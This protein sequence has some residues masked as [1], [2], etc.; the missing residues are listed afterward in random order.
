MR[1]AGLRRHR[2]KAVSRVAILTHT[3]FDRDAI[4]RDVRGMTAW[5]ESCGHFVEIF[6][7][8]WEEP[9]VEPRPIEAID[10]LLNDERAVVI[11]HHSIGWEAG[12]EAVER[13]R[14]R[15]VVKYHNVTPPEFFEG[16]SDRYVGRCRTGRMQ[17]GRLALAD[18]DRYLGDSQYNAD[19]LLREGVPRDRIAVVPPFHEVDRLLCLE[20]DLAILDACR[21]G[22]VNVLSVGR[23]APNKGLARLI[24]AFAVYHFVYNPDSR[25]LIVGGAG[26]E[27][28]G[29]VQMLHGR[30]RRLGL[31]HAVV[32][33][34]EVR[35]DR[36][37][38]YYLA[39]DVLVVVS[40]HEGFCVP[41]IEAMGLGIPVVACAAGA[42][43]ETLASAGI[44]WEE[45]DPAL[46]A[47]SIH[48]MVSDSGA[49]T[50]LQESA[51][52]RYRELFTTEK[53]QQRFAEA[54]KGIL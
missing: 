4:A 30:V 2:A 34:G 5:L 35:E 12:L 29:F 6:A 31:R 37:K 20:A 45:F 41:I 13:A 43:E 24:D 51:E 1:A 8:H 32:F 15:R 40:E 16:V 7:E 19:E 25:L 17:L 53:I 47:G 36:L 52:A 9:V 18:C 49:R 39:A 23:L 44:A 28:A 11:Y 42:V 22:R 14:A 46:I 3:L 54:V 21:D 10:R 33:L 50:M 38:A 27:L 48:R 26:G